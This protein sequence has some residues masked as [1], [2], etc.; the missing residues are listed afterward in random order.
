[1]GNDVDVSYVASSTSN[2]YE[3]VIDWLGSMQLTHRCSQSRPGA[4]GQPKRLPTN[5]NGMD[6]FSRSTLADTGND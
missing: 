1:M 6:S 5:S 2:P 4:D 3:A